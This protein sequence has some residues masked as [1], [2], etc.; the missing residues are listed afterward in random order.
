M[1]MFNAA[2]SVRLIASCLLFSLVALPGELKLKE[3]DHKKLGSLVSAYFTAR[4][5]ERGILE[6]LQKVIDQAASIEK[7]MKGQKLL[8]AVS[9]WEEVFRLATDETVKTTLK[10][11]GEV[12]T[13]KLKSD[14][15]VNIAYCVPKKPSKSA[16]PLVLI[17]CDSGEDPSTHLETF[18]N[19][20]GLRDGAVLVAIN[21]GSDPESWGVFGSASAP[22]GA[23]Q[24]T[25]AL[26]LIQRE[27]LI[28][29][30][31][32]FLAGSGKGFAAAE[33]TASSYPQLF[34]GLIGIGDVSAVEPGD[35]E[36][37]RVLPTLLVKGGEGAK[38]IEAKLGE[39][40][41]GNCRLEPEGTAAQTWDWM[42]KN[43]RNPYP[44][45]LT[46][47]P[48]RDSAK[49][50]HWLT[51]GGFQSVE[52]PHIDAKADRAS[53]TV[54][55]ES[56]KISDLVVYLNDEIVDLDKPVKFSINGTIHERT[57]ERN[58][59]DMILN[60]FYGGDW[61]RVFTGSVSLDVPAK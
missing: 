25:T 34:A 31:R 21:L 36:N 55:I 7:R 61:G 18:W 10:K 26:S 33:A 48:K 49:F 38:A 20:A 13:A 54:T 30:N 47:A 2:P 19:D 39:Y 53:N 41:Y 57:V 27:F 37:F 12:A 45:H 6:S 35:M 15:D 43:P 14:F 52:S 8:A 24:V 46:F 51:L 23:M 5:E 59:P 42:I 9:D 60:Q 11:R 17:G 58:T 50:M 1:T 56:K 44:A 16:L 3:S 22:G 4:N 29:C 40:G 28:D 32:R